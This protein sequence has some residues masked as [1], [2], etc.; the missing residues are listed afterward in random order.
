[1]MT[2][3][4]ERRYWR[5]WAPAWNRNWR[6]KDKVA[7]PV[8]GRRETD[9]VTEVDAI[10]AK[11]AQGKPDDN[12]IRRAAHFVACHS[13][14]SHKTLS[15]SQFDRVLM[16]FKLL[17]DPDNLAATLDWQNPDRAKLKRIQYVLKRD[18]T[19]RY[20]RHMSNAKFQTPEWELLDYQ[21]TYQLMLT[22]KARPN[23]AKTYEP[24]NAK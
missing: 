15:A 4:Q 8:P 5:D 11:L 20:I 18:F 9:Y 7:V 23:A 3:K 21:K 17:A 2:E 10:A 19:D 12:A 14:G 22:L 13:A 1:M 24:R 6:I 16:L